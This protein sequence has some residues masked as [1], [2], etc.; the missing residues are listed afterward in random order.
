MMM[1]LGMREG[2]A[3]KEKEETKDGEKAWERRGEEKR[4]EKEKKRAEKEERMGNL[5]EGGEGRGGGGGQIWDE[6]PHCEGMQ[7]TDAN[8]PD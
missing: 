7:K 8:C 4:K 3:G 6:P 5:G 1:S 2:G